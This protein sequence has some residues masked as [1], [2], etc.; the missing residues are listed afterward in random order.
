MPASHRP[1]GPDRTPTRPPTPA[2]EDGTRTGLTTDLVSENLNMSI[3]V[4]ILRLVDRTQREESPINDTDHRP[5]DTTPDSSPDP[6]PD[7]IPDPADPSGLYDDLTVCP[8]GARTVPGSLCRKC[9][10]RATWSRRK[11]G[12]TRRQ[13]RTPNR[14]RNR[15]EPD[16][17]TGPRSRRRNR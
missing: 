5:D 8:C 14:P 17:G 7:S 9:T 10:A 11:D 15:T 12:A 3:H 2:L 4:L 6:G 1:T 13:R 16:T